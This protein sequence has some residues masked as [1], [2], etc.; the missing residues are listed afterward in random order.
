MFSVDSSIIFQYGSVRQSSINRTMVCVVGLSDMKMF[1]NPD[2]KFDY[3]RSDV[4]FTLKMLLVHSLDGTT[5]QGS[6]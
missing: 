6:S 5:A 4:V 1:Q 2:I 3:M